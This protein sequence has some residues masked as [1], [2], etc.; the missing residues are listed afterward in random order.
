MS[1]LPS[2][3]ALPDQVRAL[4]R[5]VRLEADGR[6]ACI[7]DRSGEI[8]FEDEEPGE[9]VWLRQLVRERGKELFALPAG[10]A[11]ETPFPDVFADCD[12]DDFLLAFL[13]RRVA[14][15]V[16][17]PDAEAARERVRKPLEA[18]VDR[19]LRHQ[20]AW[21]VDERGRGFFFG[22]PRLDLVVV[23]RPEPTEG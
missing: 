23:G 2:R 9:S 16:A 8:H 6:F 10:L 11:D 18:L 7:V 1:L 12:Q 14:V 15:V 13:N 3:Q 19:L 4:L 5:G 20:P 17:C 22:R 21:R